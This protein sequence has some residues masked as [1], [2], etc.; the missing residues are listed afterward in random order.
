MVSELATR[1]DEFGIVRVSLNFAV[2]RSVFEEGSRIGAGPILRI[3]RSVLVFFSRWWQLEALYRSNVKYQ[4]DWAPRFLCF[5][6]NRE[7]PA[8]DL[9]RR[10]P[11][12]LLFYL[13]SVADPARQPSTPEFTKRC[14]L[15]WSP[16]KVCTPTAAC[17]TPHRR[18]QHRDHDG[19]SRFASG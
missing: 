3:W 18:W 16:P 17:R 15:H 8:S 11:K 13:P 19:P 7:L 6:D 12:A 4:P 1:S 14:Q 10:S 2:F 5:E 9:R